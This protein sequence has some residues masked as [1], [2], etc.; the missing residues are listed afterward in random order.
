MDSGSA[1]DL[2]SSV[3]TMS[4]SWV[5]AVALLLGQVELGVALEP[6]TRLDQYVR[7]SWTVDQGLPQS[8]VLG[9]TQTRDGYLW[10]AT[11]E[12]FVR[13]DGQEFVTYDKNSYPQIVSNMGVSIRGA[14]DGTLYVG[15]VDGGLVRMRGDRIDVITEA[16]GLPTNNITILAESRDGS[17]WIGTGAGLAHLAGGRVSVIPAAQLPNKAITALAEDSSGQL[18]VAT[19]GGL[20]TIKGWTRQPPGRRGRVSVAGR[21]IACCRT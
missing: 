14:Q 20:A 17:L 16:N 15:T 11:Q 6:V 13:F 19:A 1:A 9:V 5:A 8:T 3:S 2:P 12:G 10:I 7:A 4:K 21:A 18:W